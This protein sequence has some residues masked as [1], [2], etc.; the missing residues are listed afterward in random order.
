MKGLNYVDLCFVID[1]TGSMGGFIATAKQQL[2]D[3]VGLLS[4]DNNIDLLIGMVEYRDHPPEEKSFITRVYQLTKDMKKM[5]QQINLLKAEGGGDTPEAVYDGIMDACNKMKW[6]K[7]SSRF[8]LLVGDAQPHGFATWLSTMTGNRYNHGGD[9][10]P[11]GCPSGLDVLQVAAAAEN[12]RISIYGLCMGNM[13]LT[14]KAFDAI[15]TSTGGKATNVRNNSQIIQSIVSVLQEEFSNIEFDG[16]VL[17]TINTTG[18]TDLDKIAKIL[19]CPR[20]PAAAS[21]A[22]LGKRGFV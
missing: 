1:T 11:Q 5:Q 7:G 9:R 14:E 10:W 18:E 22:R 21:L 13:D 4:A 12:Q 20:L 19:E 16:L 15:A 8:I 6:R 17:E 3:T 2:L